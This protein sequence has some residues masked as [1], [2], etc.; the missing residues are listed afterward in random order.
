MLQTDAAVPRSGNNVAAARI[1]YVFTP[2]PSS[3]E[4]T[5]FA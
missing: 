4:L 2:N 1:G 5:F 3:L